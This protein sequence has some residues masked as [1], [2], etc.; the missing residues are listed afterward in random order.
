MTRR[1]ELCEM[2]M[3]ATVKEGRG[4]IATVWSGNN[5]PPHM[6]HVERHAREIAYLPDLLAACRDLAARLD[7]E[8]ILNPRQAAALRAVQ[9]AMAKMAPK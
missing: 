8:D 7:G 1:I 6:I 3:N 4:V 9:R 2:E 5:S